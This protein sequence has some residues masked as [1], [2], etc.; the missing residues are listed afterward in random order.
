RL[1]RASG[2]AI[3]RLVSEMATP[4]VFVPRSSPAMAAPFGVAAARSGKSTTG[5]HRVSTSMS[6]LSKGEG[7][8]NRSRSSAGDPMTIDGETVRK[9]AKL[10]HIRETED[11]LESLAA[12]LSGIMQWIEQLREVDTEGVE[13]MTSAVAAALPM[14]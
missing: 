3:I 4:M 11:R 13:P 10:A 5:I 14:R 8:H 2:L 1:I 12:E 6:L 7:T 9:V